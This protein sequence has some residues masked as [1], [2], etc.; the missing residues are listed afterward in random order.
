MGIGF[1]FAKWSRQHCWLCLIVVS[2]EINALL[3]R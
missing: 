1:Q 3:G 2:R